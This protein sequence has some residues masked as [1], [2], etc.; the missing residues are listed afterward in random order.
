[1]AQRPSPFPVQADKRISQVSQISEFSINSNGSD[2][3][4]HKALIGPWMLGM[5]L[6]RGS[7]GKFVDT[8][9]LFTTKSRC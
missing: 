1:M 7:S 8:F 6:G 3:K 9:V 5:T 4:R 2:A